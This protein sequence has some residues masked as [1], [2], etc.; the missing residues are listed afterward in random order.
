MHRLEGFGRL[1]VRRP[2]GAI[3]FIRGLAD[4]GIDVAQH[5]KYAIRVSILGGGLRVRVRVDLNQYA[6]AGIDLIWIPNDASGIAG[7]APNAP[8]ARTTLESTFRPELNTYSTCTLSL[9]REYM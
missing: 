1:N 7:T 5:Y 8:S 6:A 2:I 3:H 9:A 4:Q